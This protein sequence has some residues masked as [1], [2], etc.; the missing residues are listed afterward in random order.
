MSF[1]R[2][3]LKGAHLVAA[4]MVAG[5]MT[6]TAGR[7]VTPPQA[8][9]IAPEQ[10]EDFQV[11]SEDIQA[12]VAEVETPEHVGDGEASYYGRELTG[13]RTA[14]SER[15]NPAALTAAHRNLPLGSKLRVINKANGKSVVVRVNDR[16]PF[17]KTRLIDVSLAAAQK[18]DMIRSGKAIVRL[19][20]IG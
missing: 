7:A 8:D 18:I 11:K 6:S 13:N 17:A 4:L 16:G 5:L 1:N 12:S 10:D 9:I 20:R 19:E 14:S 3:R 15:F 2:S